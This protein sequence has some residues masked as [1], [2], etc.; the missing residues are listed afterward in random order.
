LDYKKALFE[1]E[2]DV[3]LVAALEPATVSVR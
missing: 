3:K 2:F 1:T